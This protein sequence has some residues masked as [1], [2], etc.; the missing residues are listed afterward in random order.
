M[1]D[2][3]SLP[4]EENVRIAKQV[5]DYAHDKGVVVEAELG[6]LAGVEDDV[7]V[8]AEDLAYTKP[9]QVQDFVERTGVDSLAIAIGTS[10]G[11]FK[12][13]PGQKPQLRFDILEDV[14]RRLPGFPIVLQCK[15]RSSRFG[16]K[17]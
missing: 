17:S 14:T 10:H 13:K 9:E 11:A 15:L 6:T 2:G 4:Y 12:F 1:F 8:A 16:R 3:S 7:S 5:A